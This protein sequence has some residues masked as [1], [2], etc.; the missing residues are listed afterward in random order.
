MEEPVIIDL[1]G[2]VCPFPLI[3]A[4]KELEKVEEGRKVAILVTD[5]SA[6]ES[7]PAWA[8]MEGHEV[9][10][11]EDKKSYTKILLKRRKKD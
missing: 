2:L 5:P 7:I 10:G 6:C 4:R 3:L 8:K 9:I 11:I 1:R